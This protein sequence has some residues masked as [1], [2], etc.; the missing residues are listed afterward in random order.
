[1]LESGQ[2]VLLHGDD[3]VFAAILRAIPGSDALDVTT[4]YGYGGPVGGEDFGEHY[5]RWAGERGVVTSFFRF[6]PLYENH[7]LAGPGVSLERLAGTVGWRLDKPDLFA[8]MHRSHR[9]KCR[10]A[11][12]AGVSVEATPEPEALDGFAALYEGTMSRLDAEGFY[13]FPAPYWDALAGRLRSR[14]V[15]FD[16][17]LD[18]E[19]IASALCLTGGRWLHY[20]LGATLD[21]ARRL[22]ASN[23]LLFEA[24]A[25]AKERGFEVFHLGGGL[26]GRDD[27]LLSFKRCFD[28][29]TPLRECWIGKAVHDEAAYRAFAGERAGLDGFFPAYRVPGALSSAAE[30]E[31]PNRR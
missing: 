29:E 20:H 7:R 17:R 10:K 15:R 22:G 19:V 16:A 11:R 1:L 8:A 4:P 28:P 24:G 25:W 2:P 21:E 27:S 9:N 23:L 5:R 12:R 13:F 3:A 14:L 31:A 26:G 6:H 18:R 30:A